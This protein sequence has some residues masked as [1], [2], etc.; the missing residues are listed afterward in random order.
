MFRCFTDQI[1][2]GP[3]LRGTRPVV[4]L[5]CLIWKIS[6]L[7]KV[8]LNKQ[9]ALEVSWWTDSTWW[10][11]QQYCTAD[12]SVLRYN[13]ALLLQQ[14]VNCSLYVRHHV[15]GLHQ[16]RLQDKVSVTVEHCL[17]DGGRQREARVVDTCAHLRIGRI[18]NI[19]RQLLIYSTWTSA[20]EDLRRL[21][22][23]LDIRWLNLNCFRTFVWRHLSE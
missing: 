7:N 12:V 16:V 14:Q 6:A 9:S 23:M 4:K 11:C 20:D 13:I 19:R 18:Y 22:E 10:D 21:W 1:Q 15:T 2:L 5:N 3:G 8:T 17:C